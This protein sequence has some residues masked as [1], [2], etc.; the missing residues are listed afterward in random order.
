MNVWHDL[1]QLVPAPNSASRSSH[2]IEVDGVFLGTAIGHQLGVR[3]IALDP[4]LKEMDQSIW[5]SLSY[6]ERSARQLFKSQRG[7]QRA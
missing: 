6:A 2:P 3:F 7:R 4:L 1:Q 5:P